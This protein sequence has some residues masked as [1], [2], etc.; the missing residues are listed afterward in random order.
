MNTSPALQRA[1]ATGFWLAAPQSHLPFSHNTVGSARDGPA[2]ASPPRNSL[3]FSLF[4]R[5]DTGSSQTSGKMEVVAATLGKLV[6][7]DTDLTVIFK[8]FFFFFAP[9]LRP[10]S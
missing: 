8:V 9:T 4:S 1:A 5:A 6:P 3:E 2:P 10:H 7:M